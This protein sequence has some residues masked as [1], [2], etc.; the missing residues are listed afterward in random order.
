MTLNPFKLSLDAIRFGVHVTVA[1]IEL[2]FRIAGALVDAVR[3]EQAEDETAVKVEVTREEPEAATHSAPRPE[4][5]EL[6][7]E[8]VDLAP[9]PPPH[10][11]T[12]PELVAEFAEQGAEDGPSAELHVD[13]PWEGYREMR[14]ADIASRLAEANEAELAVVELYELAH[15]KRRSI[16]DAAKRRNRALANAPSPNAR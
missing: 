11:D 8:P 5:V 13:E 15:G 7:P 6:T 9:E 1:A 3:P 2:P 14:V 4:P 16:L 12:E 10:I